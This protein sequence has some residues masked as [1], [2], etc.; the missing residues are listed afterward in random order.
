MVGQLV[1]PRADATSHLCFPRRSQ[2]QFDLLIFSTKGPIAPRLNSVELRIIAFERSFALSN[3][4]STRAD[5][6]ILPPYFWSQSSPFTAFQFCFFD[7]I[8]LMTFIAP[9]RRTF[10]LSATFLLLAAFSSQEGKAQTGICAVNAQSIDTHCANGTSCRSTTTIAMPA[11][12]YGTA[13]QYN[14]QKTQCCESDLTY[15]TPAGGNCVIP[16]A[17]PTSLISATRT[18]LVRGCDGQFRAFEVSL[19]NILFGRSVVASAA[20]IVATEETSDSKVGF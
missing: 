1:V 12:G 7:S 17:K 6:N 15:I 19:Q 14:S 20:P 11:G 16:G 4:L 8:A 10:A 9:S 5:E 3:E 2:R 18:V 13:Q